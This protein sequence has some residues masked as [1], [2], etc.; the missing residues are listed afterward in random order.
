MRSISFP[1]LTIID[2]LRGLAIVLM[3]LDHS[4]IFFVTLPFHPLDPD[5]SNLFDFFLR[6]A[7]HPAAPLFVF[8][9]GI[10]AFL[11]RQNRQLSA[12][13]FAFQQASRGLWMLILEGTV[14]HLLWTFRLDWQ[15]LTL[16][17]FFALGI[18]MVTLSIFAWF[19]SRVVLVFAVFILLFHNLLDFYSAGDVSPVWSL[20]HVYGTLLLSNGWT[21]RVVYPALPWTGIYLL[22]YGACSFFVQ[23]GGLRAGR[24]KVAG[25]I[26]GC[27][28]FILRCLDLLALRRI[29]DPFRMG[30]LRLT[31]FA[32]N[33]YH[34]HLHE[35]LS[36]S[37][38]DFLNVCKY[39]PSLVFTLLFLSISAFI[40]C[41]LDW[42]LLVDLS[43]TA[44]V[45]RRFA[46]KVARLLSVPGN[47][48]LFLYAFHLSVLHMVAL[49]VLRFLNRSWFLDPGMYPSTLVSLPSWAV[50]P[51]AG[52]TVFLSFLAA[53]HYG[54]FRRNVPS[55]LRGFL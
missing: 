39:P 26:M 1:R 28:F 46:G 24:L 34:W 50:I 44:G 45:I 11:T 51:V 23:A 8:L 30:P 29:S 7:A 5:S 40:A 43:P 38:M 10:S 33:R 53:R 41:I 49:P 20:F 6:W 32:G 4:R 27:A 18:A 16:Q 12:S 19:S 35:S 15:P 48:P 55:S 42:A 25:I 2:S 13:G 21:F 14:F 37:A 22:G 47:V 52:I 17:V 31:F 54:R 36:R 9:A 3:I